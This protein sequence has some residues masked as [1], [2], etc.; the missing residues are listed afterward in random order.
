MFRKNSGRGKYALAALLGAVVGG[1]IVAL[2]TH[3]VPKALSGVCEKMHQMM[4]E[5]KGPGCEAEDLCQRLTA[6]KEQTREQAA[7][8][9]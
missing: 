6:G 8:E 3:A 1:S 9:S 5:G 4:T 2:T 7:C